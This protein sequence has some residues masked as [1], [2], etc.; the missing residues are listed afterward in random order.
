MKKKSE[1]GILV[2]RIEAVSLAVVAGYPS[3]SYTASIDNTS[4]YRV[5]GEENI[6]KLYHATSITNAHSILRQKTFYPGTK[7]FLGPGIYFS[8]SPYF[9]RRY[10][11]CPT[12]PHVVIRCSVDVGKVKNVGK[13]THCTVQ[14]LLVD[15]CDSFKD[16][17]RDCIMLPNM[18]KAQIDIDNMHI[19]YDL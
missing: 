13:V 12:R 1:Q 9:A 8:E 7:G 3:K 15:G 4:R 17:G 18:D 10:C 5:V 16:L 14:D 2:H 6:L 11:Q 19:A